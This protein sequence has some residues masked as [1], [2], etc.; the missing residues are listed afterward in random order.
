MA[1]KRKVDVEESSRERIQF[2]FNADKD[3]PVGKVFEYLLLNDQIPN[4][5]GKQKG[6]DAMVAF[7]LPYAYQSEV[8]GEDLKTMARES[9]KAL[10][11]QIA[12]IC[13]TFEIENPQTSE[14]SPVLEQVIQ[15]TVAEV[16]QNLVVTG[17]AT[18]GTPAPTSSVAL[19]TAAPPPPSTPPGEGVD[20]DADMMLIE[21]DENL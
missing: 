14:V 21:L 3:K 11:K 9:V 17:T 8:S 15:K 12:D 13:Q 2:S 20:F 6:L 10:S 1:R 19:P 5:L 16:M 7:W 4:R 18:V